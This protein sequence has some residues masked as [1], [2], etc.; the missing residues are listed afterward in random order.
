MPY[1]RAGNPNN[2]F[3]PNT[4]GINPNANAKVVRP[5][6][7]PKFCLLTLAIAVSVRGIVI[8][9]RKTAKMPATGT[10]IEKAKRMTANVK[11]SVAVLINPNLSHKYPPVAFPVATAKTNKNE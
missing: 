1:K 6:A 7:K 9:N 3:A 2:W 8:L 11:E 4:V 10:F 5:N